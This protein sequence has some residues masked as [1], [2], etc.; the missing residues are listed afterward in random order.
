MTFS[1]VTGRESRANPQPLGS[2]LT[3]GV[4]TSSATH[5]LVL[6]SDGVSLRLSSPARPLTTVSTPD[7]I[8]ELLRN[9]G[10]Q[11]GWCADP[12]GIERQLGIRLP[13]GVRCAT[14]LTHALVPSGQPLPA[15]TGV[16]IAAGIAAFT[17]FPN[18]EKVAASAVVAEE[19]LW[20]PQ[21]RRG[22]L[23]DE[24]LL[25]ARLHAAKRAQAA[26]IARWGADLT[27][28]GMPTLEWLAARGVHG[29]I[30]MRGTYPTVT[31]PR[32]SPEDAHPDVAAYRELRTVGNQLRELG[33][34]RKHLKTG[35]RIYPRFEMNSTSSGRM[36]VVGPSMHNV[37]PTNRD[38]FLAEPGHALVGIDHAGAESKVLAA[39]VGDPDFTRAVTNGDVYA[40]LAAA[41]GIPRRTAKVA[42]LAYA[43]GQSQQ[44]LAKDVGADIAAAI[45]QA[46]P[47]L[48]PAV[49]A[50]MQRVAGEARAGR[51]LFT[52]TGRRL[53]QPDAAYKASN[54]LIQGSARDLFGL[55]VR[56]TAEALGSDALWLPIH[57]ELLVLAPRGQQHEVAALLLEAMT[58]TV[59]GTGVQ[60][61]GVVEHFGGRWDAH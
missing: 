51:P 7:D 17:E 38:L 49:P 45:H 46:I 16:Q 4:A 42:W 18:S 14:T 29:S 61:T 44:G 59:P 22:F 8:D 23:V 48:W 52:L 60:L 43:Y 26:G 6:S 56:R 27:E 32:I 28:H 19:T 41:V 35:S 36:K 21:S 13:D 53:T 5:P 30:V 11:T 25:I 37:S 9:M 34:W 40:E 58:V 54:R 20:R 55:G 2:R 1:M 33:I 24:T 15:Q 47:E 3:G 50:W 39:F 10:T 12:V 57:D 31:L